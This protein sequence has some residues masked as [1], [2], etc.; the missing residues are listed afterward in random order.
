VLALGDAAN[1]LKAAT[2]AAETAQV[3]LKELLASIGGGA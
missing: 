3:A 1:Q 2:E